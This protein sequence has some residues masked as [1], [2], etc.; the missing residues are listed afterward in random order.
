MAKAVADLVVLHDRQFA[1]RHDV[2][3]ADRRLGQG[4]DQRCDIEDHIGGDAVLQDLAVQLRDNPQA[5]RT[6]RQFVGR[7]PGSAS[8]LIE[9]PTIGQ[10]RFA[11][12][13]QERA[14]GVGSCSPFEHRKDAV[15]RGIGIWRG[16]GLLH[17]IGRCAG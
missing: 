4:G 8:C 17:L 6:R 15:V 10:Q 7:D 16:I 9:H 12:D 14:F 1:L 2:D 11:I 5:R 13:D 3:L